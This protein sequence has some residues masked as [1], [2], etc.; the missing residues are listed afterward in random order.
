M[1]PITEFPVGAVFNLAAFGNAKVTSRYFDSYTLK[2]GPD[3]ADSVTLK[4]TYL[5]TRPRVDASK[6]QD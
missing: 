6:S 2:Y 1:K 5:C 4:F 3:G